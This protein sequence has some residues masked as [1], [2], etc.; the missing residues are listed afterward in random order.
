MYIPRDSSDLARGL[1][2]CFYIL[3]VARSLASKSYR[4]WI[5]LWQRTPTLIFNGLYGIWSCIFWCYLDYIYIYSQFIDVYRIRLS[6]DQNPI[7]KQPLL[8]WL[9][10]RCHR[11]SH[12]IVLGWFKIKGPFSHTI[13]FCHAFHGRFHHFSTKVGFIPLKPKQQ[14]KLPFNCS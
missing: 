10:T 2:F 14:A 9:G 11:K 5:S 6:Y 8:L 7:L 4:N 1:G 12:F 3:F 13:S